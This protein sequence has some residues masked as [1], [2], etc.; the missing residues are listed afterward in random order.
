MVA[1]VKN[2]KAGE[3]ALL[4]IRRGSSAVFIPLR[5]AGEEP[6]KK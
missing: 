3:M 2:L 4:R 1:E 5:V 6:A